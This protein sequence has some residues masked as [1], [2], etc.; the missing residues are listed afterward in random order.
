LDKKELIERLRRNDQSAFKELFRLYFFD[1]REYAGFYT[2]DT[3]AAEDLVQ[4]VFF[5]IWERRGELTIHTSIKSYLVR[6]VHNSSIQ[7][8]RHRSV[9]HQ[10]NKMIKDRLEE[11]MIINKLCFEEGICKLFEN[12][13]KEIVDS[14]LP[15][16]PERTRNIYLMSRKKNM[17]NEEIAKELN[18]TVKTIEYHMTK[19]LSL[20]REELREYL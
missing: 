20:L 4:D 18:V 3:Q 14:S 12:E 1:L 2:A 9:V 16:L 15:R 6:A 8:L 5:R 7:Y 10:H 19:A 17:K 13:I 11:S